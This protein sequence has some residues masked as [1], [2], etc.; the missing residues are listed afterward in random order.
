VGSNPP[1]STNQ[2]LAY[3]TFQRIERNPRVSARFAFACGPREGTH[4]GYIFFCGPVEIGRRH[5]A[6]G[7]AAVDTRVTITEVIGHN[8]HDVSANP[9]N[10]SVALIG[11]GSDIELVNC[12]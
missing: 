4:V 6:P 7:A 12:I 2:S 8:Q 9:S 11:I 1:L 10:D 5:A 3:R